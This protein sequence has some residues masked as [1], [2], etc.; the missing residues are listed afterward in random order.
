MEKANQP[1]TIAPRDDR[2]RLLQWPRLPNGPVEPCILDFLGGRRVDATEFYA[3]LVSR[4][5]QHQMP[6]I[7]KCPDLVDLVPRVEGHDLDDAA[8]NRPVRG[9]RFDLWMRCTGAELEWALKR[10]VEQEQHIRRLWITV[11]SK[12]IDDAN[13]VI[14]CLHEMPPGELLALVVDTEHIANPDTRKSVARAILIGAPRLAR[15][16]VLVIK[17]F[18]VSLFDSKDAT[19]ALAAVCRTVRHLRVDLEW[20]DLMAVADLAATTA[21]SKLVALTLHKCGDLANL[22]LRDHEQERRRR[23]AWS[24]GWHQRLEGLLNPALK[25]LWL[26]IETPLDMTIAPLSAADALRLF[27]DLPGLVKLEFSRVW[28]CSPAD[29]VIQACLQR[30]RQLRQRGA[31]DALEDLLLGPCLADASGTGGP[32]RVPSDSLADVVVDAVQRCLEHDL[33]QYLEGR[34]TGYAVS[35]HFMY[36]IRALQRC[37][38][39]Q[40]GPGQVIAHEQ[41]LA[42]LIAQMKASVPPAPFRFPMPAHGARGDASVTIT[43]GWLAADFRRLTLDPGLL[44][45]PVATGADLLFENAARLVRDMLDAAETWLVRRDPTR[46]V[47]AIRTQLEPI[48]DTLCKVMQPFFEKL[49]CDAMGQR[50]PLGSD[51]HAAQRPH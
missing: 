48:C 16:Q 45:L 5:L 43:L 40:L 6:Q 24:T 29:F 26:S 38:R 46:S 51:T 30:N 9:M 39:D 14:E 21:G 35:S 1:P 10:C 20:D 7:Q 50:W 27:I 32:E 4:H 47:N 3:S 23:T 2:L 19:T 25:L 31:S 28:P 41:V 44:R 37:L 42:T 34:D 22:G 11:T 12:D 36:G 15:L 8:Q 17:C 33:R 13:R 49:Y 18:G